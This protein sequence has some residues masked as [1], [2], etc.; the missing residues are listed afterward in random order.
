MIYDESLSVCP[1]CGLVIWDPFFKIKNLRMLN[2]ARD[3]VKLFVLR[4]LD[5]LSV[6]KLNSSAFTPPLDQIGDKRLPTV[7]IFSLQ[8]Q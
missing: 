7:V 8:K 5:M 4:K 3:Q 2:L 6:H 1:S